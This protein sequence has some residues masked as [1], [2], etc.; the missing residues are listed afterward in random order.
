MYDIESK[1]ARPSL[2]HWFDLYEIII[3]PMKATYYMDFTPRD[4]HLDDRKPK[5]HLVRMN[6]RLS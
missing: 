2:T 6:G 1:L 3:C 5:V 4:I